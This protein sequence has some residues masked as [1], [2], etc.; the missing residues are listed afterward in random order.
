MKVVILAGGKGTRLSQYTSEIPKPMIKI[1]NI[2][3]LE[4]QINQLKRY[5]L[6]DIILSIGYLGNVIRKYFEDGEKFGVNITYIEEKEPLGTGGVLSLVKDLI[7][8]DFIYLFGDLIFNIDWNKIIEFHKSNKA[9]ATFLAHPNSHP[10]D[11]DL[12]IADE[13]YKIE[14][15]SYKSE[16]RNFYYKNLVKSGIHILS[17]E[18]F[19]YVERNKK[20]D[21]EKEVI[22]KTLQDKKEIYAYKT[23]EYVKDMGTLQRLNEVE[24]YVKRGF[25][26]LSQI[27]RK[28]VF[29]DRDGVINKENGFI[30]NLDKF[31]LEKNVAKAIKLLNENGFLVIVIT[32]QPV[33]ARGMCTLKELNDIHNKMETLLGQEGAYVDAIYYCPHHPDKGFEGE[34]PEYKIICDCRKPNIGMITQAVNENNI[35][36]NQS[37][38]VGDMTQDIQTGINAGIKTILV[39]TGIAGKDEKYTAK[40]DIEVEDLLEAANIIVGER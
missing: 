29:L 15:I 2:P 26:E 30:D 6:T 22:S 12:L 40:A 13:N 20:Q 10:Y 37:Y 35:D 24:K 5:G 16:A 7:N 27:K 11:S 9:F 31:E 1:N 4:H 14:R 33:I 25:L 21:F 32:N 38:I 39:K 23:S 34:I 18:I 17:K 19:K 8:E 28:C 3:I 36:L